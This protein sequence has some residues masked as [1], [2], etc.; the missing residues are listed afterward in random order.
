[1]HGQK[2]LVVDDDLDLTRLLQR[3]FARAGAEV[4]TAHDG[5]EGL[6]RFYACRPDLVILDIVMPEMNGWQLCSQISSSSDVPIIM[7]SVQGRQDQVVRGLG[8]GAVDYVTKPFSVDV[9]MA[10]AR[11]A[12]R[13]SSPSSRPGD[14]CVY[15]DGSLRVDVE[16][17][18]VLLR[19]EP[20]D[21]TATE[22]RL[23]TY[24]LRNAGRVLSYDQILEAVWGP[25]YRDSPQYVHVY[26]YRLRQ[27]L[28]SNP[29][30]PKY[31]RTEH[32]MGYSF[33]KRSVPD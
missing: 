12:L 32:G 13:R 15:D 7:L 19:G 28:E 10:R 17:R 33:E 23:L 29:T 4:H 31:L 22:Y 11:V 5:R 25:E 3:A 24:L 26:I 18:R 6:R 16:G 21:L 14:G 1:M 9:L 20:V 2:V 8:C 27:K 30:F